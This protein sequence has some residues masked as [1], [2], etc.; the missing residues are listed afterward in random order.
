MRFRALPFPVWEDHRGAVEARFVGRGPAGDRA[1]VYE[2]LGTGLTAPVAW[3]K[4]I[5]S[6]HVLPARPGACG[7]GDALVSSESGLVL[8]VIVADCVPVLLAG[9]RALATVHAGWR[10][11]ASDVIG[12][13]LA[14]LEE[15]AESLT[16]WIGPAIGPCCYE[17][18]EEVAEAVVAASSA[19]ARRDDRGEKPHLDLH[20]AAH[21]QLSRRGVSDLRSA[22][23]CTRCHPEWLW[24][25]RREGPGGGRNHGFLW[26]S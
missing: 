23:V 5:H 16:A 19:A 10:G 1:A 11:L 9:D 17:V 12:L 13:T 21:E 8:S 25:Y 3:A 15:P 4:Q 14:T 6:N 2:A 22:P 7:E 18:S 24:S 26:R 20:A